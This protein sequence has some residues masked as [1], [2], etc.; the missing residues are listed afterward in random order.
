MT[1]ISLLAVS[2]C[3]FSQGAQAPNP[4]EDLLKAAKLI[5]SDM[6]NFFNLKFDISDSKRTHTVYVRKTTWEFRSL[7][8][9][10]VY[11]LVW[12]SAMAPTADQLLT[13]FQKRFKIGGLVYELPSEAQKLFR[14]RFSVWMP[15]NSSAQV[16]STYLSLVSTTGDEIEK[17]LN[18]G[19]E[20]NF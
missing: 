7:K 10:E 17:E 18:P 15:L 14:I 12:E 13:I 5:Y 1:S 9:N 19:K 20:D 4:V 2:S 11:G 6:P 16:A 8:N 3:A